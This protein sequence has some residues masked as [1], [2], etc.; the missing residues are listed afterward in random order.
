MSEAVNSGRASWILLQ[1]GNRRFA[2]PA[3]SVIELAPPVRLHPFPHT[4]QMIAG[5]I[6]RRGRIVPVYEVAPILCGRESSVHRFY[7]IA[8][9]TFGKNI[10]ASAIPVNGECELAT[11]E[12]LPPAPEGPNYLAGKLKIDTEDIAVLDFENLVSASRIPAGQS[13]HA[14]ALR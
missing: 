10:E 9:R 8:Q 14:E 5:V 7:L 12:M 13:Q 1:V 6:V 11:A 4:S 3:Q 2:L